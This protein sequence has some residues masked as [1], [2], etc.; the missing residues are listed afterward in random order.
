M[1]GDH[2]G[3]GNA[4]LSSVI[5]IDTNDRTTTNP[6]PDAVLPEEGEIVLIGTPEGELQFLRLFADI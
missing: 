6:A 2:R 4:T 3:S 1:V 5:G